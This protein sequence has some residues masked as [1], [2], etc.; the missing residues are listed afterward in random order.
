MDQRVPSATQ[1]RAM[2]TEA[3]TPRQEEGAAVK[4]AA[5]TVLEKIS[6][7]P[8]ST[9]LATPTGH[10]QVISL[11]LLLQM[12]SSLSSVYFFGGADL[13]ESK[14]SQ[15]GPIKL[16]GEVLWPCLFCSVQQQ[17]LLFGGEGIFF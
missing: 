9:A 16:K 12:T 13:T 5:T 10:L 14:P 11:I 15:V 17:Q 7:L 4:T 1:N 2:E 3:R 8:G 6:G